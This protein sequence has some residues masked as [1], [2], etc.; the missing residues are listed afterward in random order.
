[1]IGSSEWILNARPGH[2]RKCGVLLMI[3]YG[4]LRVEWKGLT[5]EVEPRKGAP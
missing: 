1:M 5:N 4:F 3:G 2:R